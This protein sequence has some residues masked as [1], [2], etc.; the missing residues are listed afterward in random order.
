MLCGVH[1]SGG[2]VGVW[3]EAVSAVGSGWT[4]GSRDQTHTV[5]KGSERILL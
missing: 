5:G 4:G 1:P 2:A 3:A